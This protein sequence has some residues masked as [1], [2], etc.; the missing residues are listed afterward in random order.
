ME[1]KPANASHAAAN[2]AS[3]VASKKSD[4]ASK[5]KFPLQPKIAVI[6]LGYVG[7]PLAVALARHFSV[8][9][10]DINKTRIQELKTGYDRTKEVPSEKLNT[11]TL[12]VSYDSQYIQHQDIYIVT[13]PTPVTEDYQPD[14]TP[15]QKASETVGRVLSKNA[16]VVY[17]STVYP[18]VT[19]DFCAPILEKISGLKAGQDF[20]LGYSPERI[21]PG[22]TERTVERITKVVS[23]QTPE[24]A[25]ILKQIYGTLNN[26]NIFVAKDIKTA[27]AAKVIEN[28]QRDINIAFINE[29]ATIVGKLGLSIY[30]VLEAAETKWNFLKFKPGLVGGHCIGVDPY[31]LAYCAR[32][33]DHEPEV[34]L[35]GRRT[36]ESMGPYLAQRVHDELVAMN[37]NTPA[38]I[39]ILGVTF[40][41]DIPDLRN[42]KVIDVIRQLKGMGHNVD[43]HD[44]HA[45]SE[46]AEAHLGIHLLSSFEGVENYDCIIGAV[47]HKNYMDFAHHHFEALLKPEGLVA[48]FKNM[49]RNIEF[50]KK[51]KYWSI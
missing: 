36:N 46:E 44:P 11:S 27:E 31:Y 45:H 30:D 38:R 39:L 9:G 7:L 51:V 37:L 41:E 5:T 48:D 26:G 12:S 25:E 35:A 33:L 29:I 14:L 6:G 1:S 19:E 17:E 16:I 34:L 13:V 24:V 22:D 32:K 3:N 42:T 10:F 49:W 50:P 47:S 43:V 23:G 20:F 40:K 15:L 21:N 18:G 4:S 8:I 28:T 2:V